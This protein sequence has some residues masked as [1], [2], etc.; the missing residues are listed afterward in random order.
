MS[1][2]YSFASAV[3][4]LTCSL[5]PAVMAANY[6]EGTLGDLSNSGLTPTVISVGL[7]SNLISGMTG[8]SASGI[9]RDYFSV[10]IP[11]GAGLS[12]LTVSDGTAVGIAV[13]FIGVQAG[14]QVTVSTSSFSAAGL[15][16]WAHYSDGDV[17]HDIL[18]T[19]AFPV[20]GSSGFAVPLGPGTYSFWVQDF[21][22]G[23]ATYAFNL[24]VTAAVPEPETYAALV[25]GLGLLGV[26]RS[27]RR[28]R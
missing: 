4:A 15:L 6:D 26:A 2:R 23:D 12:G 1:S 20:N 8:S 11:N 28:A 3:L 16:G 27:R 19:M 25:L 24:A 13:S 18:P 14:P 9:D 21:D 7:G 17:G 10:T 5:P 22:F